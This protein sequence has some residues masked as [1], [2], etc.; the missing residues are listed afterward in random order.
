[1]YDVIVVGTDGSATAGDAVRH[2]ADLARR[3]GARLHL[4]TGC[5]VVDAAKLVGPATASNYLDGSSSRSGVSPEG[6]AAQEMLAAVAEPLRSSGIDV[7]VWAVAGSP[8]DAVLD[9]ATAQGADLVV[10]GS[11]GMGRRILGSVPNSV[12][13]KA[14]C[15]VLIVKTV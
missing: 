11:R 7:S 9:V 15:A 1:M 4:V 10:V 5:D 6:A 8:A 3:L 14:A 12:A 13:H 2:A